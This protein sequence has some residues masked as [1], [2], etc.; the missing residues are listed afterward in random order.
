MTY[1]QLPQRHPIF[2]GDDLSFDCIK[3]WLE[4]TIAKLIGAK[5]TTG[6]LAAAPKKELAIKLSNIKHST[7][8]DALCPFSKSLVVFLILSLF[9]SGC[10]VVPRVLGGDEIYNPTGVIY[11]ADDRLDYY[12]IYD[13]QIQQQADAVAAMTYSWRLSEQENGSFDIRPYA[14][15][16]ER[17]DLEPGSLFYDQPLNSSCTAFLV[18]PNILVT[19]G[20]CVHNKTEEEI[21]SIRYIFGYRMNSAD[22][23]NLNIPAEN[24][25]SINRVIYSSYRILANVDFAVIEL[26]RDVTCAEP[27]TIATENVEDGDYV[28]IIGYPSG[29]PL[30]YAPNGRVFD[31]GTNSFLATIDAFKGNSGSPV[32]N[33]N[34]E[35][36]GVYISTYLIIIGGNTYGRITSDNPHPLTYFGNRSTN[37]SIFSPQLILP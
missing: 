13:L 37:V 17:F 36:V 7:R 24:V 25:Y 26:D 6:F 28:Y 18:A 20:H 10:S 15:Y 14:T 4:Q 27:L 16:G 8:E 19:A 2:R 35:V 22:E 29:L 21:S 32:F 23:A 31:T 33:A 9:L 11:G 5:N 30:K 1:K 12:Q 34:G 3:S